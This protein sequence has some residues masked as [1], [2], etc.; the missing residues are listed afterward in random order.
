MKNGWRKAKVGEVCTVIAGQSPDGSFYNKDG[1]GMAF[2]Q[3]KKDFGEK[4]L[5]PPTT[6]TRQVTRVAEAGDI[7]MSVRA[8]VGP[9]NFATDQVCIGRGLAAIRVSHEVDKDFLF[10]FFKKHESELVGSDGAVFNSINRNEIENIAFPVPPIEEQR[11]IVAILDEAFAAIDKAKAN[12]EKNI[13]NARELFD[14]YLNNIFSNPAPDWERR[15]L[16]E[17]TSKI[18]SGATPRGGKKEYKTSGISL[19]RSMNVHDR[20][21][22]PDNLAFIDSKQAG[23]LSNVTLQPNDVL[24]NIT[25]ASIARSC[26]CPEELLPARVNQ[27]VSIVRPRLTCVDPGFLNYS[28]TSSGTKDRLLNVGVAGGS[29]RQALTKADLEGF[30]IDLPSTISEQQAL[31]SKLGQCETETKELDSVFRSKFV[32]LDQLKRSILQKA[33]RGEI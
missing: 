8:P 18:G 32:E 27:H 1:D 16:K 29:T 26:V 15:S 5:G 28:L 12:T 4:F 20:R 31:S 30:E 11:R 22:K 14:S 9:V 10:Y 13:Q 6:W 24:I 25:G 23:E 19:I 2:Y 17:L 33:F 3:G 7:L 21:F